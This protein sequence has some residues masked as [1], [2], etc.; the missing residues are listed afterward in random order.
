MYA[1]PLYTTIRAKP[2]P[3]NV[4]ALTQ[5]FGFSQDSLLPD[6]FFKKGSYNQNLQ[7]PNPDLPNATVDEF[8]SSSV[9][10]GADVFCSG[11]LSLPKYAKIGDQ[12]NVFGIISGKNPLRGS[13]DFEKIRAENGLLFLG[14]GEIRQNRKEIYKKD[15]S[16]VGIKMMDCVV[17]ICPYPDSWG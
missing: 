14:I 13:V 1:S 15:C 2:T 5:K 17:K 8:V 10:R 16:G 12:V 7:N 4:S 11:C 6:L 3:E 9:L